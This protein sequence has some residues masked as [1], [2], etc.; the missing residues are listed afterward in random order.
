MDV[1]SHQLGERQASAQT[2]DLRR[3]S[4]A[5]VTG[6]CQRSARQTSWENSKLAPKSWTLE[7]SLLAPQRGDFKGTPCPTGWEN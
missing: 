1:S 2:V 5:R 7:E 3:V 4:A 6:G